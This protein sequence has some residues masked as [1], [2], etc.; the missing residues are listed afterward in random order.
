MIQGG[1]LGMFM[2]VFGVAMIFIISPILTYFYGKDGIALGS[3]AVRFGRN[4]WR[5]VSSFIRFN[6]EIL[7]N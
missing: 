5:S 7:E 2:L 3:V 1:N 4:R 6:P